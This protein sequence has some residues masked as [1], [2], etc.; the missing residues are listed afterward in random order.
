M[1][2]YSEPDTI[3]ANIR[4]KIHKIISPSKNDNWAEIASH[5]LAGYCF[6][7]T[8]AYYY[9]LPENERQKHNPQLVKFEG[10]NRLTD[11]EFVFQHCYLKSDNDSIIDITRDQFNQE[12]EIHTTIPYKKGD[13]YEFPD[14][15]PHP[16]TKRVLNHLPSTPQTVVENW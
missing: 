14:P 5:R 16:K 12:K 4:N 6:F 3:A 9:A 15:S 7:A 8:E 1:R 13:K 2:I 10:Y 11:T